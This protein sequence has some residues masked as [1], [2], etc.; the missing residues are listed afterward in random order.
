VGLARD[1][2]E[3]GLAFLHRSVAEMSAQPATMRSLSFAVV[4]LAAAV[5]VLM[6]ARLVREHWTLICAEPDKVTTAQLLAGT[7]KTVTPDQAVT[8][9]ENVAGV[10]MTAGG[11]AAR[12]KEIVN[13]RN[14]AIHFAMVGIAPAGLQ[15]PLGRGLDFV[16]WF[17]DIEFRDQGDEAVENLVE[18]SIETLTTK[19]GQLKALVAER[20]ASIAVELDAAELC[21]E[22]PRCH[23]A[24]LMLLSGE[25]SRCAFCLWK[26]IDGEDCAAEYAAAVLGSTYYEAIKNGGDWPVHSCTACG[27]TSMVEGVEQLRPDPATM[28]AGEPPCDWKAPAHWCC[29]SCGTI[30]D[31]TELEHCTRCSALTETGNDEGVPVCANCWADITHD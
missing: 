21:V 20:L 15:G 6:K 26:P 18:E 2:T 23:Q 12:V 13:L 24:T 3:N 11:H 27:A 8:R 10:A 7:A 22:C 14:R 25:V 30:A 9:L 28:N 5:E 17:L 19:V 1:L 4:D 29:F 31:W 16:L